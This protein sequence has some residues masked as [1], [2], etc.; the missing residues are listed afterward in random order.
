VVSQGVV[1][2]AESQRPP[3]VGRGEEIAFCVTVLA[4]RDGTGVVVTGAAGVGKTR[5]AAEVLGATE[6]AGYAIVRV[7]ATEA[8]RAI[9]L[10][11][12][13]GVLPVDVDAGVAPVQLL[14][15]ARRAISERE[16]GR[17]VALLVDDA[18]LL[19][20]ASAMLVQQ[21]AAAREAAVVATIRSGEPVPDAWLRC[22]PSTTRRSRG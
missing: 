8:G 20:S 10:G 17:G 21:L 5:L 3:L 7:T 4:R 2:I 6:A 1:G 12:F 11:P 18:H 16:D 14:G 9:P 13:A 19:D 22:G 15:V